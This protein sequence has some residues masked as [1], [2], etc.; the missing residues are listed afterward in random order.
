MLSFFQ[1]SF[2]EAMRELEV[3]REK[4]MTQDKLLESVI[5]QRDTLSE[6][7]KQQ[8]SPVKVVDPGAAKQVM[9]NFSN[10]RKIVYYHL[11][12]ICHDRRFYYM[13]LACRNSEAVRKF[14]ENSSFIAR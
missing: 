3:L 6:L 7:M 14:T 11:I 9:K 8:K 13:I 12:M 2:Q 10:F 1:D 5:Q 4:R